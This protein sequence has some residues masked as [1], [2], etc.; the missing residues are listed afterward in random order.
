MMGNR[1]DVIV[2]GGGPGGYTA[3]IRAAQAGL[4]TAL[5]EMGYVGGTCLN[6][7]CIPTK[8][9]IHTSNLFRELSEGEPIGIITDGLRCDPLKMHEH[10]NNVVTELRSGVEYLLGAN[11][12]TRYTG[13]ATVSAADRSVRIAISA[14]GTVSGSEPGAGTEAGNETAEITAEHIIVA[15]GS[16][17][18]SLPIPGADLPGI[19]SSDDFLEGNGIDCKKLIVLGGGVIAVEIASVYNNLGCEV[20]LI[21]RSNGMLSA[22]DKD[23]SQNLGMILKS[24]GINL[25]T[26]TALQRI[27]HGEEGF[28]V[29]FTGKKGDLSVTGDE[30]LMAAGRK[31]NLDGLFT[32]DI[33]PEMDRGLIINERFETNV[34][35]I[36]AI[37]DCV[38]GSTQLAHAAAAQATNAV[39]VIA[40][41]EPEV[42]LNLIPVCVY[43]EPEIATVG[44]TADDAKRLNIPVKIGKYS[45]NAHGKSM[46]D[47]QKRSFIKLVFAEEDERLLGVQM[48]CGRAT[49][50]I[51]NFVTAINAGRT[52][53]DLA[54]L[55]YPHPT[56]SEAVA[57][58]VES[59]F[60]TAVH[61]SPKN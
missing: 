12:I 1:Y 60:G 38:S 41:K 32:G 43:T 53:G 17:P 13:K 4:N 8:A 21:Q 3:A 45:M 20:T 57:E 44:L 7:G 33:I 9:L 10:K 37:G 11:K 48:M 22:M 58:A 34:S 56:Y 29:Y 46:I 31:P 18:A 59:V 5:V 49:D 39:A 50:M 42:N 27:E 61:I 55:I 2:V 51:F 35:G 36:Y 15:V 54:G 16:S 23:I 19:R 28:T 52:A 30:I 40:G 24:R 26:G 6:R 14:P 25:H 47:R